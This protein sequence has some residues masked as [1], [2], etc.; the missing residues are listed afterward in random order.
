M[1]RVPIRINKPRKYGNKRSADGCSSLR[2]SRRLA[3]LKILERIGEIKDLR[4]QVP[5]ELTPK[6]GKEKASFYI[7]D[8]VYFRDGKE[9]IE[10][11]KGARTQLYILKRKMMRYRY[12][13][14]ILET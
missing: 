7:A 6:I 2:E 12:G 5:F 4:W 10:D 13:I 9:V 1:S 8:F 11:C 14:K 3:D